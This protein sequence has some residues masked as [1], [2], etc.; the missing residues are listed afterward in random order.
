VGPIQDALQSP[1]KV[2]QGRS[3]CENSTKIV[4]GGDRNF[5]D[6]RNPFES[7]QNGGKPEKEGGLLRYIGLTK[8]GLCSKL[9]ATCNCL[10][11]IGEV[12]SDGWECQ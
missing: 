6:Q 12:S 8:R 9:H 3:V 7:S 2:E 4:Q 1:C 11:V 5:D 10:L